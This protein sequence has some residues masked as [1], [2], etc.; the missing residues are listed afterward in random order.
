MITPKKYGYVTIKLQDGN[1]GLLWYNEDFMHIIDNNPVDPKYHGSTTYEYTKNGVLYAC[2]NTRN[3]IEVLPFDM[4]KY[5]IK[6][7]YYQGHYCYEYERYI[8]LLLLVDENDDAFMY[9][10]FVENM[11]KDI[12]D[13]QYIGKI[14]GDYHVFVVLQCIAILQPNKL[15]F[16]SAQDMW[17]M[18]DNTGDFREVTSATKYNTLSIPGK[19]FSEYTWNRGT[20][21]YLSKERR[22]LIETFM[23]CNKRMGV[24]K[25]P[26]CVL[27]QIFTH[28]VM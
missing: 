24:F 9:V 6:S 7:Y 8:H 5:K 11:C 1:T 20:H 14:I 2:N 22:Q 4:T 16:T 25:I 27:C 19:T 23:M 28:L 10:N 3:V 13:F 26:Y 12:N 17:D 21:K 18:E 15:Q